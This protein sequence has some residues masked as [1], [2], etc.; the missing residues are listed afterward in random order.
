MV[1]YS[2]KGIAV[3]EWLSGICDEVL[4]TG[5]KSLDIMGIIVTYNVLK[6]DRSHRK[7]ST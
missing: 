1:L 5:G 3:K 7:W 2:A 6:V 4:T